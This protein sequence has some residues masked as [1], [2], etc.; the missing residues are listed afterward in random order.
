MHTQ[1]PHM[2]YE[3]DG[4]LS[5][6]VNAETCGLSKVHCGSEVGYIHSCP[7]NPPKRKSCK[8]VRRAE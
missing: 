1:K 4:I 2:I 5:L 7:L 8:S 3:R 6:V